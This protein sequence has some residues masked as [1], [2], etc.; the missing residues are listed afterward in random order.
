M[1]LKGNHKKEQHWRLC[2]GRGLGF[3]VQVPRKHLRHLLIG[4]R[5]PN[6]QKHQTWLKKPR[7]PGTET[8]NFNPIIINYYLLVIWVLIHVIIGIIIINPKDLNHWPK[9]TFDGSFAGDRAPQQKN[10]SLEAPAK[11]VLNQKS[12]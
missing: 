7:K 1:I 12:K 6:C 3:R 9:Q 11:S 4:E 10:T 2:R 5:N 8:R